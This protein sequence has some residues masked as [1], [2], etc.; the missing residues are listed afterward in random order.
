VIAA[1]PPESAPAPVRRKG[2]MAATAA[3]V[4]PA[5]QWHEGMLLAPQHFQW[6]SQRQEALLHYHS[7][8]MNPFHWGVRHLRIDPVLLVDGTLRVL[9]LEAVLPDGLVVSRLPDE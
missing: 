3:D 4:P 2:R 1:I 9:E 5:I 8:A 6:Q 7:A